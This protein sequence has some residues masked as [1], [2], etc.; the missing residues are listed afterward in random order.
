MQQILL[1]G[2]TNVSKAY[3]YYLQGR[4][5]LYQYQ[6]IN[7]IDA[8]ID[9]FRK[10]A[11]QDSTYALALAG[12]GEAYWRKYYSTKNIQWVDSARQY[13]M[14]SLHYSSRLA[15]VHITL[16]T[17]NSGTG[18][19]EE[20]VKHFQRAL[21]LDP[22]NADAYRGLANVYKIINKPDLAESAFQR[23]IQLKPNYWANYN[24]L[25]VFYFQNGRYQDASEQFK[26]VAALTPGNMKGFNNL[27]A[28]YFLQ[29]N[30]EEAVKTFNRSLQ[31]RDNYIAY[32]NLA[33]LYYFKNN[34]NKSV[35]MFEKALDISDKDFRIWGNLAASYSMMPDQK[36]NMKKAYEKAIALAE[37]SLLVN[38]NDIMVLTDI[39]NFYAS[40]GN[41]NKAVSIAEKVKS[42]NPESIE[43]F[44]RLCE[45]YEQ[46]GQRDNALEWIKKSIEQG[47]SIE[48]IERTPGLKELCL[49]KRFKKFIDKN[50]D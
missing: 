20:A 45:T 13:C 48:R 27:G 39:A 5:Y 21:D 18:H 12:L 40:I 22:I 43:I 10:A 42:L 3:D 46:I 8:A 44:F 6:D 29:E 32:S 14:H 30:Y 9:L 49:D 24:S 41:K 47:Y 37:E 35:K 17:V 25:G 19:Y 2:G 23:A 16:G 50:K 34:Y 31:I 4:G 38:P 11:Q 1:E 26:Q 36:L 28:M 7:N 33:T 15:P